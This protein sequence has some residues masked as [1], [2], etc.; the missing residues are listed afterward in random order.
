MFST[1]SLIL[2]SICKQKNMLKSDNEGNMWI[3]HSRVL[4]GNNNLFMFPEGW[5]VQKIGSYHD[6][7]KIKIDDGVI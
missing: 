5:Y 2:Y 6:N 4:A 1:S 3:A 7:E